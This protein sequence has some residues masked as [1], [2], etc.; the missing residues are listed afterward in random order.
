[1]ARVVPPT[2]P[3]KIPK[4]GLGRV[5]SGQPS[6]ARVVPRKNALRTCPPRIGQASV[7]RVAPTKMKKIV[8]H[9]EASDHREQPG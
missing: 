9:K 4:I 7:A 2:F 6:V 1:M 8:P 3:A 5:R